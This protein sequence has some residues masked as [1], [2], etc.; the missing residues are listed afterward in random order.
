MVKGAAY[1]NKAKG[2]NSG[3]MV[4]AWGRRLQRD[5]MLTAANVQ[6]TDKEGNQVGEKLNIH[7]I[8]SLAYLEEA[9]KWNPDGNFDRISAMGMLMILRAERMKHLERVRDNTHEV[10]SALAE[11]TYFRQNYNTFIY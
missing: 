3:K 5:W 2:T 6:D 7:T 8:R 1:G 10:G 9:I 4:N 11:D